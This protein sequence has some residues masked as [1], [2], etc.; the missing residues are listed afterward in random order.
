MEVPYWRFG[1]AGIGS[2]LIRFA[3]ILGEARYRDLAE[4]AANSVASKYTV[5]PGQFAGLTGIGEFLLD[6][7]YFTGKDQYLND[8]FKIAD[9]VL[10]FQI[11]RPEGLAWPGEELLRISTD[12]GTG[13]A[14]VGMFLHRLLEPT[15]RLFH[16]FDVHD[17]VA[18]V[19]H[20][21]RYATR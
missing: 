13:S 8:A 15:G 6:M 11:R 20:H 9:G 7:Y 18:A 4:K 3:S 14:G 17:S 10:L 16:E 21:R 1:G 19:D 2:V 5:F 12:Y